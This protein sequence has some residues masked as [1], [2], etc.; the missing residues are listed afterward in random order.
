MAKDSIFLEKNTLLNSIPDYTV[1]TL[2]IEIGNE[3]LDFNL[4]KYDSRYITDQLARGDGFIT[5]STEKDHRRVV[6]RINKQRIVAHIKPINR[7]IQDKN[8]KGAVDI[9]KADDLK[10]F[11]DIFETKK[12]KKI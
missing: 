12:E 7:T 10:E 2:I 9:G 4:S 11:N 3:L 6:T 1:E 8:K 5:I